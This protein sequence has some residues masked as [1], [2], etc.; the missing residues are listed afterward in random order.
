M[1][2]LFR[3]PYAP[4]SEEEYLKFPLLDMLVANMEYKEDDYA[5]FLQQYNL[6]LA[7]GASYSDD[8]K[9]QYASSPLNPDRER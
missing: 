7:L 6:P 3:Q 8:S 2:L 5:S 9:S 4:Q 1:V